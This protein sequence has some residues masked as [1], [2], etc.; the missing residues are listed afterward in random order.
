MAEL[1]GEK[2]HERRIN[3]VLLVTSLPLGVSVIVLVQGCL[4][5]EFA[6]CGWNKR[7][8]NSSVR[9]APSGPAL[10]EVTFSW[11]LSVACTTYSFTARG[12]EAP[13][14]GVLGHR[15]QSEM[16]PSDRSGRK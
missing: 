13:C 5:K 12:Y 10:P 9:K 8:P 7:S 4:A 14:E 15:H 11:G 1:G 3:C 6:D 16:H 2:Q